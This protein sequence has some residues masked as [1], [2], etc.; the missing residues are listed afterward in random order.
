MEIVTNNPRVFSFYAD[1]KWVPGGPVRVLEECRRMVHGGYSL[2]AHPLLGDIHLLANPF[3]TVIVG[4][5]R[6]E[7]D[8]RSVQWVEESIEK[9]RL[10]HQEMKD[11]RDLED[12]QIIDFE[13]FQSVMNLT[14]V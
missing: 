12:Y 14:V 1:V 9:L 13:L 10:A 6:E 11:L 8:P 3:R 5:K 4:E 2:F 7:L